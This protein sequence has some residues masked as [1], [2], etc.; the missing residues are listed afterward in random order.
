MKVEL[1]E[2]GPIVVTKSNGNRVV[3]CRCGKTQNAP[4]CDKSHFTARRGFPAMVIEDELRVINNDLGTRALLSY[5][6]DEAECH[7]SCGSCA[8]DD[9]GCECHYDDE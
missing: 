7:C 3:L 4:Y 8:C 9:G 5:L 2:N 6:A 1:V